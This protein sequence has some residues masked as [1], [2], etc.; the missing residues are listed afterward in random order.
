M[1]LWVHWHG[2]SGVAVAGVAVAA[3]DLACSVV[4]IATYALRLWRVAVGMGMHR[5]IA[6]MLAV[7]AVAAALRGSAEAV[8]SVVC[9]RR[10]RTC[11]VGGVVWS[12]WCRSL[13]CSNICV[14][15]GVVVGMHRY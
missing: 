14:G 12:R 15:N 10:E 3:G 9:Y 1:H 8:V 4:S 2:V 5:M 6:M 7:V 13:G 11:V